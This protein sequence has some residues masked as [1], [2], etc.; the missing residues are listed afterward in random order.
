MR[1][2]HIQYFPAKPITGARFSIVIPTWNNLPFLQLCIESIRK[3][4]A[5]VHEIIL[6]VN[7][8]SD[9]TM[10]WLK[11][12]PDLSFSFSSENVG[13][14]YAMN[15]AVTLAHTEYIVYVNDDMYLCPGWDRYLYEE[16]TR[17]DHR[18][19]FLSATMIEAHPQSNCSLRGDYGSRPEN[20]REQAL[21]NEFAKLPLRDW[22]GATWPPCLVHRDLWN[23]VGG[24]SIEF[25]PGLYSDPDFSMKLWKAGVR[26]FKGVAAARAYHFGSVST[27]KVKKNN[28]YFRFIAKWG[29][30]SRTFTHHYLRRGEIFTGLLPEPNLPLALRVKNRL[31]RAAILFHSFK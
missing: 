31:K 14:C 19:F 10:E 16:V 26:F 15:A 28:G 23:W 1:P 29:M 21:L 18:Y 2:P 5:F 8:G 7:E 9:G 27:R 22:A 11:Q 4:S 6:H 20:F 30:T 3:H 25:S 17:L 13:V 24:Y 12:Q